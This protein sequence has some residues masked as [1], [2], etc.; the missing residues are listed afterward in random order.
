MLKDRS[1]NGRFLSLFL[2]GCFLFSYPVLTIFNLPALVF[3]I[4]LFFLYLFAAWLVLIL[5][6]L[7]FERFSDT[8]DPVTLLADKKAVQEK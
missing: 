5:L 6:V 8:S 7:A 3:G 1:A 4:P 2:L